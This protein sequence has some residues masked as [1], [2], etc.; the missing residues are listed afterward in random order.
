M[1]TEIKR[2]TTEV[3]IGS[4]QL[5]QLGEI[6]GIVKGIAANVVAVQNEQR[7]TRNRFDEI[8]DSISDLA[9][10]VASLRSN[11]IEIRED[12]DEDKRTIVS[13]DDRLSAHIAE[14][15][16]HIARQGGIS[17]SL[18]AVATVLVAVGGAV[19]TL[20]CSDILTWFHKIFG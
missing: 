13:V 5:L 8:R 18:S 4:A 16:A 14:H 19:G 2:M 7:D 1:T 3:S 15:N 9:S 20:F 11:Q 17:W 10:E 12:V 6:T